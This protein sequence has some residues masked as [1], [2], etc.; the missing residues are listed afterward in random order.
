MVAQHVA[1]TF[2]VTAQYNFCSSATCVVVFAQE[3]KSHPN[4]FAQ[5]KIWAG[6]NFFVVAPVWFCVRKTSIV[7]IVPFIM[8]A[9]FNQESIL[10]NPSRVRYATLTSETKK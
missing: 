9:N 8:H 5:R 7:F 6:T 2:F 10:S 4:V 1:P 3:D